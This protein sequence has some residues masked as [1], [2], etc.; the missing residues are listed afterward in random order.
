MSDNQPEEIDYDSMTDEEINNLPLP[1]EPSDEVVRDADGEPKPVEDTSEVEIEESPEEEVEEEE[2]SD[3][4]VNEEVEGETSD[5][6]APEATEESES[7]KEDES[8]EEAEPE[9]NSFEGLAELLKE[10]LKVGDAEITI[11]SAEELVTLAKRGLGANKRIQELAPQLKTISM[12]EANG[13]MDPKKLNFLIALDKQDPAAIRQ[14]VASSG[15]DAFEAS[16][17]DVDENYVPE[18][19]SVS[20][21]QFAVQQAFSNI[22]STGTY[23]E[24]L[25]SIDGFSDSSKDEIRKNPGL[26]NQL[27]E[28]HENGYYQEIQGIVLKEKAMGKLTGLDSLQAYKH[29]WN[30]IQENSASNGGSQEAGHKNTT[31]DRNSGEN[32]A[33]K[34]GNPEAGHKANTGKQVGKAQQAAK[35]AAES[36]NKNRGSQT[37]EA[38]NFD[39]LS[40][41]EIANLEVSDIF[42]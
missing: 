17:G 35:K 10:P 27:S 31:N 13:L 20:D 28:H 42:K 19:R 21:E 2:E 7:D 14:L 12:L 3:T 34:D 18:D 22:E 41:E 26:I 40:D 23:Q 6:E 29:V 30:K 24:T 8:E 5:D 25:K 15:V 38:I 32:L 16:T 4:E 36:T 9:V 1:V 33:S 11:N 37:T 39:E